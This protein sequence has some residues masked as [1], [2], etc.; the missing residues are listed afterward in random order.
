MNWA[1]QSPTGCCPAKQMKARFRRVLDGVRE[2]KEMVGN[3]NIPVLREVNRGDD[4]RFINLTAVFTVNPI[5]EV[6]DLARFEGFKLI[7]L[8]TAR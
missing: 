3:G 5:G 6:V 8:L 7:T 1:L 4:Q 2:A